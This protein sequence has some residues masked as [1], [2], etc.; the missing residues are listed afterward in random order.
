MASGRH[1]SLDGQNTPAG[2]LARA[3]W[4]KAMRAAFLDHLAATCNVTQS[5]AAAGVCKNSVYHIRRRD[6]A[7]A[8]KW[9]EALALGYQMIETRLL[10]HVLSGLGRTDCLR[11]AGEGQPAI[12]FESALRLLTQHR[13]AQGKPH[14]GRQPGFAAPEET[15]AML[16]KRLRVIEARRAREAGWAAAVAAGKAARLTHEAGD[17]GRDPRRAIID[18]RPEAE[19]R[20]GE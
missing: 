8:A 7:F 6:P 16:L 12:D 9:E 4:S 1:T 11:D 14:K 13:N 3:R 2:R 5:A 18:Q 19:P 10:G 15:D 20:D 17:P